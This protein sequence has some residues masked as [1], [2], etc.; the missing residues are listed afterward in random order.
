MSFALIRNART[1]VPGIVTG[2]IASCHRSA[3]TALR[4]K[5]RANARCR[6]ANGANTW[7]DL[8]VVEVEWSDDARARGAVVAPR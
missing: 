3:E 6:R 7:L 5:A 2:E 8:D 4:A 1:V